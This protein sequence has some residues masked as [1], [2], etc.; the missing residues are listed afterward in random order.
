M[1]TGHEMCGEEGGLKTHRASVQTECI[2]RRKSASVPPSLVSP[3]GPV[4]L[5][6]L[7]CPC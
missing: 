5:V 7:G 3:S 2:P 6:S 4:C 1:E